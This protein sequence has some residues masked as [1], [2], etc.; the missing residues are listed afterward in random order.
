MERELKE[1]LTNI[2]N[3][4][5]TPENVIKEARKLLE[6]YDY[7]NKTEK[8]HMIVRI[9]FNEDYQNTELMLLKKDDIGK[10]NSLIRKAYK[11][12]YDNSEKFRKDYGHVFNYIEEY[13]EKQAD[14]DYSW[15]M[16][17]EM[18]F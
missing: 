4:E 9:T 11:K 12:Y 10:A 5:L 14:F 17:E 18:D 13:L 16:Y 1:L 2:V 7:T 3:E 15:V 8:T 6:E